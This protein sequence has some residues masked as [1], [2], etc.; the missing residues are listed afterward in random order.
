MDVF[1]IEP[2]NMTHFLA[3]L[4][5]LLGFESCVVIAKLFKVKA[6][7]SVKRHVLQFELLLP[8]LW[9]TSLEARG[10]KCKGNQLS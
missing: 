6:N 2:H 9:L 7:F 1:E 10:N 5:R 3:E 4:H 8:V